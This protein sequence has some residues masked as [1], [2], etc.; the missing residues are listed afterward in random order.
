MNIDVVVVVRPAA[1]ELF[2]LH[3]EVGPDFYNDIVKPAVFA[4]TRD[5]SAKFN[6][7]EIATQTHEMEE[8]IQQALVAHLVGK[9]LELGEVAIQHFDLPPEVEALANK[10]AEARCSR[11]KKSTCTSPRLMAAST[12]SGARAW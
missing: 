4:A 12:P 11:R 9:H 10:K 6:H 1:Q 3:T 2:A 5:A 7:M 8:A